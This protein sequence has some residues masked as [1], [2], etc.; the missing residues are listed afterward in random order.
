M[1]EGYSES[2]V[3]AIRQLVSSSR[4]NAKNLRAQ[5]DEAA[6][7]Q[8]VWE[9]LA[10]YIQRA[11]PLSILAVA[12]K[13]SSLLRR[14]RAEGDPSILA[15]DEIL[16]TAKGQTE[17]LRHLLPR[18]L[19]DACKTSHLPLDPDSR[20][21]RYAFAG[22]FFRVEIDDAK[23]T[24]RL[25]DNGG[26]IARFPADTGAIVAAIQREYSRVFGRSFDGRAFL[27]KLRHHYLAVLK[28][29]NQQDGTSLPIR[30]ITRRLG[31][32]E[33]GFRTDE[34]L[35]DLSRLVQQGPTEIDGRQLD[36][37]HTKDTNQGMLLHGPAGYG[38]VG[39]IT[40]RRR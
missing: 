11:W 17:D 26:E 31:K 13:E 7:V 25:S 20:H 23:M 29:E 5:A 9:E 8:Q 38:Y 2:S 24:A 30:A 6:R 40:F 22:G 4:Q 1:T 15:I 19:E 37:Q 39:F 36:L 12:E 16:A 14:M 33:K 34:F 18:Y 21:P 10:S 28:K 27:V 3:D 35:A 32:N